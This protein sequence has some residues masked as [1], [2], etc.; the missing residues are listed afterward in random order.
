MS[1]Y[2]HYRRQSRRLALC[3]LMTALSVTLLAM[4][5]FVPLATFACPMLAMLCL[6]PVICE[7]GAQTGLMVY[8]A[9]AALTVL[10]AADK[11]LALFYLFLGWYPACRERLD[12]LP[13]VLRALVKCGVFTMSMTVMYL[14]ILYLFRL[15]AVA[16]EF[17][18]Y[19][20][21]G[22]AGMLVVG[23]VT[24]LLLDRMLN[25]LTALY[26]FKRR[27]KKR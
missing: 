22:I 23:N 7:Y 10:L 6:I 1:E 5:S 20:M 13:G 11:E 26:W 14:L 19:T 24:F 16:A 17:A 2:R 12:R 4:G 9:S 27:K 18:G 21:W 15:E 25:R 8:A 3:G